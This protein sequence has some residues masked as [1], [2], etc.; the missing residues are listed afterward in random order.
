MK[1]ITPVVSIILLLLITVSIIGVAFTFFS[2]M[3][4]TTAQAGE[5]ELKHQIQQMS[6]AF[7]I[8]NVNENKVT[9]R[10]RGTGDIAS[11]DFYVNNVHVDALGP[12]I[13]PGSVG[14]YTLDDAQLAVLPDPATIKVSVGGYTQE[15]IVSFYVNHVVGYWKFD[16]ATGTAVGDS[17]GNNDGTFNGE[18]FNDGTLGDGTCSPGT[19][20]CPQWISNDNDQIFGKALSFDGIDDYVNVADDASLDIT[21]TI[22]VE[23]WIYP[24]TQSTH[25]EDDGLAWCV[26][27][28]HSWIEGTDDADRANGCNLRCTAMGY[29]G[30]NCGPVVTGTGPGGGTSCEGYTWWDNG[31]THAQTSQCTCYT[32]T[33]LNNIISKGDSF[34][35]QIDNSLTVTGNINNQPVT[36]QITNAWHQLVL[37]YDGTEQKLYIDGNLEDNAPLSGSINV[38]SNN[39]MIS[40]YFNGIID[41]VRIYDVALTQEEIQE[42]MN[43]QY[44]VNRTVASFSLNEGAGSTAKDSHIWVKG[45]YGAALSF[46]GIDD[47]VEIADDISLKPES[48]ITITAWIKKNSG[49]VGGFVSRVEGGVSKNYMLRLDTGKPQATIYTTTGSATATSNE[50]MP[51]NEWVDI[52]VIY[53]SNS[54]KLFIDGV[55]KAS[56]LLSGDIDYNNH[57]LYI[58]R[59]GTAGSQYFNGVIDEVKILD[60]ARPMA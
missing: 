8:E 23:A 12:I 13:T 28:G 40:E 39:L 42:D 24:R 30:G 9:I 18:S 27:A 7:I 58:G 25:E 21:D 29:D 5:E 46:D 34:S 51:N 60:I 26:N 3:L 15:Q 45:R 1:A 50:I 41:E 17:T 11:V 2:G 49:N 44:P 43:S 37:V 47:H 16:E 53:D 54:L 52:V 14:T 35:L 36:A 10:N 48:A 6:Q 20:S 56:S 31:N 33:S 32:L 22:T 4:G 19:G 55:E 57:V 38:N 59:H